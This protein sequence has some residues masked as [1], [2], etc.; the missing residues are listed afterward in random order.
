MRLC[1]YDELEN[2]ECTE[3]L[4]HVYHKVYKSNSETIE[5][6]IMWHDPF[7]YFSDFCFL[8]FSW[9]LD[10]VV[11]K[12][13]KRG[14]TSQ[15]L[16]N[17]SNPQ[18][19]SGSETDRRNVVMDCGGRPDK[20]LLVLVRLFHFLFLPPPCLTVLLQLSHMKVKPTLSYEQRSDSHFCPSVSFCV[21]ICTWASNVST[22]FSTLSSLFS[23]LCFSSVENASLV[24][25]VR[26]NNHRTV[27][28]R[29]YLLLDGGQGIVPYLY[30]GLCSHKLCISTRDFLKILYT[31]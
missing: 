29:Q 11:C 6:Y 4:F 26:Q 3:P 16:K 13:R 8:C 1:V 14:E 21:C 2:L 25:R 12:K 27:G 20:A 23:K 10:I 17:H 31:L 5:R 28:F 18:D 19:A 24:F 30:L 22:L 9:K 15:T 7:S